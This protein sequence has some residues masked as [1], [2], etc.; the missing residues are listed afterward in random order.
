MKIKEITYEK[1]LFDNGETITYDHA[2]ECCE[3]NY[4]DFEQLDD[5][6]KTT[7]FSTPLVFEKVEEVGFRF[8]NKENMFFIPCYSS[9]NGYYTADLD[10][11]YNYKP[12]IE[13][14]DLPLI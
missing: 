8:G 6:A 9:Q 5:I 7:N 14:K 1:I 3:T 12:V 10:I 4:A 11:Y 13:F 2:Q